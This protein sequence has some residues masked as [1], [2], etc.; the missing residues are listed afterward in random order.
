MY[1]KYSRI[2]QPHTTQ[3]GCRISPFSAKITRTAT[4]IITQNEIF[5]RNERKGKFMAATTRSDHM[6]VDAT[7]KSK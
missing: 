5:A 6:S 2:A 3:R 1:L 7:I 4:K